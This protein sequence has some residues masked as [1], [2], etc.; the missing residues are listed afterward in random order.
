MGASTSGRGRHQETIAPI[1]EIEAPATSKSSAFSVFITR[2]SIVS[3]GFST[4]MHGA[5]DRDSS[6]VVTSVVEM[7]GVCRDPLTKIPSR[8]DLV[9]PDFDSVAEPV[10]RKRRNDD[11][12][13]LI[14]PLAADTR[15][16]RS[17]SLSSDQGVPA[18]GAT[19]YQVADA[20]MTT[21]NG[22]VDV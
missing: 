16:N 21:V 15:E 10:T 17:E 11:P 9:V 18:A 13:Y 6:L 19:G 20:P 14:W 2:T 3:F 1:A 7:D 4:T 22:T 8:A 12:M 5:V